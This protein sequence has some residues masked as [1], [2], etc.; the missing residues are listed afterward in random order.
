MALKIK[1]N[2]KVSGTARRILK[3]EYSELKSMVKNNWRFE[4]MENDMFFFGIGSKPM[5]H[6]KQEEFVAKWQNRMFDI[7]ILLSEQNDC[8][9]S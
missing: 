4:Q 5:P 3:K 9:L 7:E 6:E 1:T 8:V 2:N